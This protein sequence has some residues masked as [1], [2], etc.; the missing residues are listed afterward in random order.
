SIYALLDEPVV[1]E[2]APALPAAALAEIERVCGEAQDTLHEVRAAGRDPHSIDELVY[3]AR[4]MDYAARKALA[5]Q[6]IRAAFTAAGPGEGGLSQAITMWR[7]L[8]SELVELAELFQRL[9]LA[10]A[11]RSEIDITLG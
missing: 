11:R 8:D 3:S 5:S 9:W 10:R 6:Q 1:G 7:A 2:A 4:M